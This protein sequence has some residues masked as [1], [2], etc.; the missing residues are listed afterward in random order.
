MTDWYRL[1]HKTALSLMLV[2][3]RSSVVIKI[4]AGKLVQL[5]VVTFSDVSI[6]RLSKKFLIYRYHFRLSKRLSFI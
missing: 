3:A 4:T 5:S 6:D 2:I 1:P